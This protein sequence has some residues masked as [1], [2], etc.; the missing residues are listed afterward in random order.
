MNRMR[1]FTFF[2]KQELLF[3]TQNYDYIWE[4]IKV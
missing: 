4:V 1:L 2:S 3:V